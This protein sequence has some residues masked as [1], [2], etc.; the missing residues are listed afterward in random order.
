MSAPVNSFTY[1][2]TLNGSGVIDAVKITDP[3][4]HIQNLSFD[5]NHYLT[6]DV[7]AQGLLEQQTMTYARNTSTNELI[8]SVTDQLNRETCY[9]YDSL[10]NITSVT[11]LCGTQNPS[12]WSYSYGPH[13]NQLATATDPLNHETI[14]GFDSLENHISIEDPLNYVTNVGYDAQGQVASITDPMSNT[15]SF[16]YDSHGDLASV[17]QPLDT[18]MLTNDSV[19]RVT[20]VTDPLQ[21]QVKM[22]YDNLGN[23]TG[24]TDGNGELTTWEY[25]VGLFVEANLNSEFGI[26]DTYS[27]NQSPPGFTVTYSGGGSAT[28]NFD[29]LGNVTSMVDGRGL[30]TSYTYD[31]LNRLTKATFNSTG[32]TGFNQTTATYTYD[33]GNRLLTAQDT[34]T[35]SAADSITRTYDGLDDLLSDQYASSILNAT[36]SFAYDLAQNRTSMTAA[37]QSP[38]SYVYNADNQLTSITQGTLAVSIQYDA[39][40]RPKNISLPNNVAGTLGYDDDSRITSINYGSL[41]NLTYQYDLDGRVIDIGGTLASVVVPSPATATYQTI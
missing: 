12:A 19:G 10:A 39:D 41:G 35:G 9:T 27:Y 16:S 7:R 38:T 5:T 25:S 28:Y 3:N 36:V 33:G 17:E 30:T 1:A 26:T 18:F 32:V 11:R 34:G 29:G 37:N 23:V 4:G 15:T 22:S 2:Y 21:D 6:S 14:F 20:V 40:E 31:G 8:T 24:T 13:F